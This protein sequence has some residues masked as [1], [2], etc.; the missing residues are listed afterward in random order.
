MSPISTPPQVRMELP[1]VLHGANLEPL[2]ESTITQTSEPAK[3]HC[4]V[5]QSHLPD[6]PQFVYCESPISQRQSTSK[7]TNSSIANSED[8]PVDN[9]GD[10]RTGDSGVGDMTTHTL[11][12]KAR[13]RKYK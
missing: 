10:D 12:R 5:S 6:I 2:A 4:Q 8:I 13:D 3:L 7:L 11:S 9:T 1:S